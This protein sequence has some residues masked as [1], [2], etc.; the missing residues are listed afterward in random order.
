MPLD[1]KKTL[2]HINELSRQLLSRIITAQEKAE[3]NAAGIDS[4]TDDAPIAENSIADSEL[5]KLM[6][7]RD[8]LI[9]NLFTHSKAD[10]LEQELSLLNEMASLDSEL[11]LQSQACKNVLTKQVIRLKKGEKASKSYQGY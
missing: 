11:L 2:E 1:I 8:E 5:T 6:S 4:T 9:R 10:E 7:D 3:E